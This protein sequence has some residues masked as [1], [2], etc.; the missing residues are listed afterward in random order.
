MSMPCDVRWQPDMA[1]DHRS[2]GCTRGETEETGADYAEHNTS[3]LEAWHLDPGADG[4][5][6]C[7]RYHQKIE[8]SNCRTRCPTT[9]QQVDHQS[10]SYR[11]LSREWTRSRERSKVRRKDDTARHLRPA[12]PGSARNRC[13]RTQCREQFLLRERLWPWF[14]FSSVFVERPAKAKC[15][16]CWHQEL[17]IC[18]CGLYDQPE[19]L[20]P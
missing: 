13:R 18:G 9:R 12:W 10:S 14:Q 1:T 17:K 11:G 5:G 4:S 8:T 19:W 15:S 3:W 20:R 2:H 16:D 7:H 6:R